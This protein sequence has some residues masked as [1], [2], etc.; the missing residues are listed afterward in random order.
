MLEP[1]DILLID[2]IRLVPRPPYTVQPLDIL[3]I[4]ATATLP[5]QPI[6]ANFTVSPDGNINLGYSYGSVRVAG[7]TLEKV[8]N[9]IRRQLSRVLPNPQVAVALTHFRGLQHLHGKH[10]VRQDGTISL[11]S[12]GYVYVTGLTIP[13]AKC[14]IEQHLAQFM[15]DPQISLD[16]LACNSKVYYVI[17]DCGCYGQQLYRLPITGNETVLDAIANVNGLP[18][19]CSRRRIWVARPS[20]AEHG[21]VQILPVDW[22]AITQGGS[23]ATNYQIFPG[24]R[25]YVRADCL[26]WLD[27]TLAAI[28]SP[29]ERLCGVTVL[30]DTPAQS[31]RPV[32]SSGPSSTCGGVAVA[33]L[34]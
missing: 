29:F 18:P 13:E 8:H 32:C 25:I 2:A 30:G 6:N 22:Q 19:V 3:R 5:D 27:D 1:P 20:P 24:D 12:Y 33:P 15:A 31:C 16:V 4:R 11:G 21:C 28:F 26:I 10:L 17:F 9:V 23:T 7:L 34:Q 14:A